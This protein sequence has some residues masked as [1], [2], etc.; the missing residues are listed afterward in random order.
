MNENLL[1][2][3]TVRND[4]PAG[5]GTNVKTFN[6][7]ANGVGIISET[8]F[9]VNSNFII[10]VN[11]CEERIKAIGEVKYC[12]KKDG[13]FFAGVEF[14][15]ISEETKERLESLMLALGI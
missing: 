4:A 12:L 15:V 6:I 11:F 5:A 3:G 7:S 9:Q 10:E 2:R 13:L 1:G 14:S 8:P